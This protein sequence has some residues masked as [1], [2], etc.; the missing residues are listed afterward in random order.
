M[1]STSYQIG[2]GRPPVHSRFK[3]GQSGNPGGRVRHRK[4][5]ERF[6][7]ALA[8]A[9]EGHEEALREAKPATVI[10]SLANQ[11]ALHAVD[12]RPSAQR[13][14]LSILGQGSRDDGAVVDDTALMSADTCREI[15]GER[16]D[17][18][19]KRFDAAI[20]AGSVDDLLAL[21][22]DFEGAADFPQSGNSAGK[23]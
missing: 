12:G 5:W 11:I 2:Y 14:V 21:A 17:E 22:A 23:I 1:T 3:K 18:F 16:Y 4:L 13:L 9:L 10:E 15:L 20:K 7:L 6:E 8:G 19:R